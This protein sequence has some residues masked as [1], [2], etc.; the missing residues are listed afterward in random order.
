MDFQSEETI[1]RQGRDG[2]STRLI[3]TVELN[4]ATLPPR[5]PSLGSRRTGDPINA[6]E[7]DGLLERFPWQQS[8]PR[9]ISACFDPGGDRCNRARP[10]AKVV[11]ASSFDC[12]VI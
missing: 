5:C 2:R 10:L 6:C 8:A 4:P 12:C 11:R 7:A 3:G 9:E 1:S